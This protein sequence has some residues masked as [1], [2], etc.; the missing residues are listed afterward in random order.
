MANI[1]LYV[2]SKLFGARKYDLDVE[3]I[4]PNLMQK[5]FQF[6]VGQ[7][8]IFLSSFHTELI[9]YNLCSLL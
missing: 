6:Q 8:Y 5:K 9:V 4:V 1:C 7:L 2:L 3:L